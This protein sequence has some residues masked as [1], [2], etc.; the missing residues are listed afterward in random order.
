MEK[1]ASD[2]TEMLKRNTALVSV[3]DGVCSKFDTLIADTVLDMQIFSMT[4]P[5]GISRETDHVAVRLDC[6]SEM[7]LMRHDM[8]VVFE[9]VA[10]GNMQWTVFKFKSAHGVNVVINLFDEFRVL[11][12]LTK[13]K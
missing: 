5:E 10:K 7:K 8:D 4:G 6:V 12:E 9:L 1:H 13:K 3:V 2:G 11:S